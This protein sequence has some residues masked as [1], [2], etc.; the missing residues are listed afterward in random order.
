M[1]KTKEL[2]ATQAMIDATKNGQ[3]RLRRGD[4]VLSNDPVVKGREHLFTLKPEETVERAT[5]APG[6]KRQTPKRTNG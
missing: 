6:E 3:V 5:A 4:T 1:A 2:V